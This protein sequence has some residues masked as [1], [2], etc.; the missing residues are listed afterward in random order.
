MLKLAARIE[1]AKATGRVYGKQGE[2]AQKS[3]EAFGKTVT[4]RI[5]N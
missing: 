1:G 2:K 3:G 5:E 4:T